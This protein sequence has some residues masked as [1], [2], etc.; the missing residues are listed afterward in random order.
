MATLTGVGGY[1]CAAHRDARGRMHGHT[2]EVTAFFPAGR[3]ALE[4]QT[5][6]NAALRV[7]DHKELPD[8]LQSGEA[9]IGALRINMP[10]AVEISIA[11][12]V[13]RIYAR[14]TA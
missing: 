3:D 1:F 12:P 9:I 5:H 8:G 4:L 6:L 2:W 7:F 10:T 11:R 13:E 14:W